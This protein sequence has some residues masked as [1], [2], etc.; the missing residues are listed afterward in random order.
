MKKCNCKI[1][2]IHYQ[3][4][5]DLDPS[6]AT[7]SYV[8]HIQS[9]LSLIYWK[10]NMLIKCYKIKSLILKLTH[11]SY[12]QFL[13]FKFHG[14]S[15]HIT[16]TFQD[17]VLSDICDFLDLKYSNS[18]VWNLKTFERKCKAKNINICPQRIYNFFSFPR[19]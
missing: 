13:H 10:K 9:S 17:K 11:N 7:L 16:P 3:K 8:Y 15:V 5:R 14:P 2:E 1:F 12:V 6:Y 19:F 4:K 18:V